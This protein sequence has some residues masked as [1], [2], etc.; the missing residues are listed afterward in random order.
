MKTVND[1]IEIKPF[2]P[3]FT[4]YC[5]ERVIYMRIT[6]DK[7]NSAINQSALQSRTNNKIGDNMNQDSPGSN[8]APISV[9]PPLL[10][11]KSNDS[12]KASIP[13][14]QSANLISSTPVFGGKT[15]VELEMN[16]LNG[17]KSP[18]DEN[19]KLI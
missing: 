7:Y 17:T 2:I 1:P 12:L 11:S 6:L 16:D 5:T 15:N 8:E 18:L 4:V 9:H 10:E 19:S 3:D 13:R 14:H